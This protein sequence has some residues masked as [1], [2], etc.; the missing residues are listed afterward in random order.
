MIL[1]CFL[2]TLL[3]DTADDQRRDSKGKTSFPETRPMYSQSPQV[4]D[5]FP[6]HT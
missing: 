1:K 2:F 3:G 4:G 6:L 5:I